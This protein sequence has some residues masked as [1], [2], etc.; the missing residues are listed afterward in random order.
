MNTDTNNG[1][2]M[3]TTNQTVNG[4]FFNNPVPEPVNSQPTSVIQSPQPQNEQSPLNN[5]MQPE[6][7]VNN[8]TPQIT[9][10]ETTETETPN[11]QQV[12]L[13]AINNVTYADTVGDLNSNNQIDNQTNSNNANNQFI[14]TANNFGETSLNELNVEGNYN[15]VATNQV[16]EP[17]DYINDPKVQANIHP[18]KANT[19]TI[20]KELKTVALLAIGL[21]LFIFVMPFLFDIVQKIIY[22]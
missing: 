8:S 11:Q 20:S 17:A 12:I 2:V 22:H 10:G 5:L 19:V 9:L 13:G 15:N 21:L 16:F 4:S 14:N 18:E 3:P 6:S 1:Q 7:T